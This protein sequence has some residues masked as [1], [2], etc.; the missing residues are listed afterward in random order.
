VRSVSYRSELRDCLKCMQVVCFHGFPESG[1]I[2]LL[3]AVSC[4]DDM[5][6]S[7]K[8]PGKV[9]KFAPNSSWKSVKE[10]DHL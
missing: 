8:T 6:G 9:Y 1:P 4:E 10:R 2:L 7:C 5:S 3:N